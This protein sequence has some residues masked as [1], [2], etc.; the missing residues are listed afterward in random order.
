MINHSVHFVD[1]NDKSTHTQNIESLWRAAKQ[2]FKAMNGVDCKYLTS[3]LTEFVWRYNHSENRMHVFKN[4]INLI[5][6]H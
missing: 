1:P 5:P 6:K 2:K 3:Y 4:I